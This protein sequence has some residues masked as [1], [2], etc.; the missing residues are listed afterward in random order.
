MALISSESEIKLQKPGAE[1]F[2]AEV[3]RSKGMIE[4]A[5]KK[6]EPDKR[7][8][9]RPSNQ[10]K[11]QAQAVQAAQQTAI[12]EQVIPEAA[13]API[14]SLPFTIAAAKTGFEGFLL[15]E[16]DVKALAPSFHVVLATYA[17][18]VKS[19]DM[20]LMVFAGG[21]ASIGLTKYLCYLEFLATQKKAETKSA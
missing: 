19:E 10:E 18:Q 21:L 3:T 7:R 1:A 2:R 9:G 13:L 14:L 6:P 20:A 8:V 15:A 17:P 11:N 4:K 16:E 5:D 12:V